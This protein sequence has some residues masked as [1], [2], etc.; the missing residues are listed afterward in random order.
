MWH[1]RKQPMKVFAIFIMII[2]YSCS[3]DRNT[4]NS[5][6]NTNTENLIETHN[7]TEISDFE[8]FLKAFKSESA[9]IISEDY[10]ERFLKIKWTEIERKQ[11]YTDC[12]AERILFEKENFIGVIYTINCLAGG[13]CSTTHLAVFD[14]S[15]ILQETIQ[16]GYN[17]SDLAGER[18]MSFEIYDRN[19]LK[20]TTETI[21][22]N[23]DGDV[24]G[25]KKEET[26][27]SL[28]KYIG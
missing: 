24:V 16:I 22:L 26:I 15:G 18:S 3:L 14:N 25:M 9:V 4:E 5:R 10:L 6:E 20:L 1:I 7:K 11:N 8:T 27:K 12:L 13:H 17:F 23:D 19:K 2:F 21:E 28:E